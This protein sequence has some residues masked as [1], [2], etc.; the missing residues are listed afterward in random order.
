VP[1]MYYINER[2]RE[3]FFGKKTVQEVVL[4]EQ[5]A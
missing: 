1:C 2:V 4:E 3:K 5:T